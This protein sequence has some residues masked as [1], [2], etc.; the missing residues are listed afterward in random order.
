MV[1]QW[2]IPEIQ[3]VYVKPK[4][5]YVKPKMDYR[6]D[7]N[8]HFIEICTCGLDK[9]DH[10]SFFEYLL[11]LGFSNKPSEIYEDSR[12]RDISGTYRILVYIRTETD[13]IT[14]NT[15]Y[16]KITEAYLKFHKKSKERYDEQ[17][18]RNYKRKERLD[19]LVM[20]LK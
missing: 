9:E 15:N 6:I 17:T 13:V 8:N 11:S 16:E 19:K 2:E 5:D 12:F 10:L 4:M 3:K 1:E 18:K 14:W 7:K 20:N